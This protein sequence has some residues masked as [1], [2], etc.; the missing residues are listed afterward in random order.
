[1]ESVIKVPGAGNASNNTVGSSRL[2]LKSAIVSILGK[3]DVGD[4]TMAHWKRE[5]V[6]TKYVTRDPKHGTNY[7]TVLNFHGE[8][9]ILVYHE[10][11]TYRFPKGL[12][13]AGWLYYTSLGKGSEVMHKDLLAYLKRSKAK[14]CFQP[15][16]HQLLLGLKAV[17]PLI[18]ASHVTVMNKEEAERLLE[19]GVQSMP[20]L[21]KHLRALGC[22]IALITDGAKGAYSYDGAEML[23]MPIMDVP[24]VERTGCGDA[25][26]TAFVAALHLGKPV[27][28]AL[29]WGTANSASVL[30]Y[31]GPQAGL[32]KMAGM[33]KFLS[34][35]KDVVARPIDGA[36]H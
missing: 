19:T 14:F 30:G 5:G 16:T 20:E 11:R 9:T 31:T 33:K 2:G 12:P 29:R 24:P 21:L 36:A 22:E 35:F 17:A 8:R 18:E 3:D 32:L 7:S 25:F 34:L 13:A 28:E 15:G 10:P 27:S 23:E 1:V 26:A 4:M 6:G